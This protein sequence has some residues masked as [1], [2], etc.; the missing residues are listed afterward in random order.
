MNNYFG[1]A[2]VED[3]W[4]EG[5]LVLMYHKIAV[6]PLLHRGRSLYISPGRLQQQLRELE[7]T[8][9]IGFTDLTAWPGRH[10]SQ[11]WVAVTFDDACANLATQAMPILRQFSLRAITYV[12]ADCIGGTNSWDRPFG[13]RAEPLMDRDQL[14]DWLAA[15]HE[16]GSHGLTHAD[17]TKLP[18]EAAEREIV[19][20]RKILEDEFG[21]PIRHFCFP[22]GCTNERLRD[23]VEAAGY[24]SAVTTERGINDH[25]TDP[26][27]LR[28]C[29]ALYKKPWLAALLRR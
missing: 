7:D 4:R 23:I 27:A 28:R 1:L 12:V 6:P 21:M 10:A 9:D 17:L 26:F 25:E 11:R 22:Y 14:H 16:I 24:H 20:S 15:G 18:I 13:M 29:M 2:S 5:L 8:H 3:Q 19:D